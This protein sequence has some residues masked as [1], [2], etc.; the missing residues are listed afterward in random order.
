MNKRLLQFL[1]VE[2]ITQSQFADNIGVARGSVSH[3]LKGRNKPGFE[4]I[5]S[6]ARHY[7]ALNL[8]W[9]VTGKGRMFKG[10]EPAE[11]PVFAPADDIM[12]AFRA[13]EPEIRSSE[14]E[15]KAAQEPVETGFMEPETTGRKIERIVVFY[16]DGT[17]QELK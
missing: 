16:S 15:Q 17:F 13:P 10:P 1:Q 9:L 8:D 14:T 4:F 3:I 6:M 2:N 11:N 5:E 12:D 7:P